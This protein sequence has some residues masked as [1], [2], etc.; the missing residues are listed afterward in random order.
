M[1]AAM[2]YESYSPNLTI[3]YDESSVVVAS[4]EK[5]WAEMF[6][7]AVDGVIDY[8]TS[9]DESEYEP[10]LPVEYAP[11]E[12]APAPTAPTKYYA[13]PPPSTY[14]PYPGYD[15]ETIYVNYSQVVEIADYS[16][17]VSGYGRN[18]PFRNILKRL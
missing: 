14:L 11:D 4:G 5:S 6:M 18:F 13:P 2:Q 7:Q 16:S 15:G 8:F 3:L 12:Y 10:A 9:D 17:S 1:P